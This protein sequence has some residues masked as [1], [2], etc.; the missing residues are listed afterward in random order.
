MISRRRL[1]RLEAAFN[2]APEQSSPGRDLK[3]ATAA[4]A[5]GTWSWDDARLLLGERAAEWRQCL[6]EHARVLCD[7][8]AW[9]YRDFPEHPMFWAMQI[10]TCRPD[11]V[12]PPELGDKLLRSVLTP[13]GSGRKPFGDDFSSENYDAVALILALETPDARRLRNEIWDTQGAR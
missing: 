11:E 8:S 10:V 7:D 13:D 12:V 3:R 9:P 2:P 6:A 4:A 5:A 1:D